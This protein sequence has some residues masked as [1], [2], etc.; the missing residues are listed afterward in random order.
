MFKRVDITVDEEIQGFS[1]MNLNGDEE[2][3]SFDMCGVCI[4]DSAGDTVGIFVQDI[5]KLVKALEEAY[6]HLKE[7][8]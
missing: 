2:F 8:E 1:Y 5:P 3:V 7:E 4:E 6:N